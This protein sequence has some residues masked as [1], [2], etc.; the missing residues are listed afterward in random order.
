MSDLKVRVVSGGLG[1]VDM[2]LREGFKITQ[3]DDDDIDLV[4]FTGGT[5]VNPEMYGQD[6]HPATSPPDNFRDEIEAEIFRKCVERGIPM[7]GICRGAQFL[8]VMNGG[9]LYQHVNKHTESHLITDYTSGMTMTVTSTHHQMMK[10]YSAA[11]FKL[12]AGCFPRG[13]FY[14]G[15]GRIELAKPNRDPEVVYF[16]QT[17]SLCHQPHPE[18]MEPTSEYYKYFFKTVDGLLKGNL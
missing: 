7:V 17:R 9:E 5:D 16:E 1:Y 8:C 11:K 18:I 13:D 6:R 10:P 4:C 14:E 2:F 12:L 3:K 15:P